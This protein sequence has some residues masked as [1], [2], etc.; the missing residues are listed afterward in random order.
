MLELC[1]NTLMAT[2]MPEVPDELAERL[3]GLGDQLPEILSAVLDREGLSTLSGTGVPARPWSEAIH[4]LRSAPD[5]PA[6]L[7]YRLPEELQERLEELLS[8]NSEDEISESEMVELDA[9][10]EVIRFFNLL[11]ASLRASLR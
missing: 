6:I 3:A 7:A 5:V 10:M 9:Y 2:I 11:K 8:L 4:F 1:Y